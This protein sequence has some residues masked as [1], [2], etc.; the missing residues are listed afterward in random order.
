[1]RLAT[2]FLLFS[3]GALLVGDVCGLHTSD[4]MVGVLVVVAVILAPDP[5]NKP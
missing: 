2:A 3:A 1:M 4:I 5:R